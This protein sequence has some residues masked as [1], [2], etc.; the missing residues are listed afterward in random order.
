MNLFRVED[1]NMKTDEFEKK[2]DYKFKNKKLIELAF[3]HSSFKKK[4]NNLSYER[5]EFL[6]DR[7][8]SLVIAHDL[9]LTFSDEDEGALSKRHSYLVAKEEL[10]EVANELNIKSFLKIDT[11]EKKYIKIQKNNSILSDACEALI[12]AIFLDSDINQAK[13]FVQKYWK[14]KIYKNILPPKDAKSML[15]EI[16]QKRC[17][18]LPKYKLKSRKGPS[19]NPKFEIEVTLEGFKSF[20]ATGRTIKIAQINA[21]INLLNFIKK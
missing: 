20:V 18:D 1:T 13:K 12:G 6:G 16:A 9:F 19:H 5:L 2:I 14:K 21:A 7:V 17:L 3:T 4:N 15:Q 10:L 11:P 8:L